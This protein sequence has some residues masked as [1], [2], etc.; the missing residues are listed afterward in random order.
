MI[1]ES[2]G[3]L[4]SRKAADIIMAICEIYNISLD[5]ATAMF[6]KSDTATLIDE[7]I[8]DLYCRSAGYLAQCVWDEYQESSNY[9]A[10]QS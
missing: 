8:A 5:E 9:S 10:M 6:Y 7:G 1:I 4:S 3:K 2:H